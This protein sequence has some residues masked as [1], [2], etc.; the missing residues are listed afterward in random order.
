MIFPGVC[1]GQLLT[2]VFSPV[3]EKRM[4]LKDK[5]V[6]LKTRVCPLYM[7]RIPL[8]LRFAIWKK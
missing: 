3:W 6:S 7:I 4:G 8:I 5:S 1:V 2:M